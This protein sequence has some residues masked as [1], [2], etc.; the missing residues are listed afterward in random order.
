MARG[1]VW[2][3]GLILLFGAIAAYELNYFNTFDTSNLPKAGL[4]HISLADVSLQVTIART[5][6]ELQQGLS[7]TRSLPPNQ[8]MLF[9]FPK[10]DIY[11]FWMKDM[12]Y[13]ID[14]LWID[15]DGRIVYVAP[16]VSPDSYPATYKSS[17]PALYILELNA[18]FAEA[19]SV[20]VGDTV[21]FQ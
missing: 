11:P 21:H 17:T 8:G 12:Q 14:I 15:E 7:G 20:R 10:A 18:G 13:P 1:F 16:N 2:F 3:A 6:A 5:P 4:Y 9:V 19:H